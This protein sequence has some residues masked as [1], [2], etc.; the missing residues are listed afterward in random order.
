MKRIINAFFYS[1]DGIK[2]AWRDEPAFREEMILAVI[3]IPAAFFLAPDTISLLLM[4]G[5][6][7]LVLMMELINTAIE[8]T[9]NH[10]STERHPLAKKA[11]D[12]ASAAVLLA[13]LNAGMIWVIILFF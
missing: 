12:T 3:M 4:I 1:L 9:V 2:A 13:L 6:I 5:S 11:K 10:I 8:A 7:L